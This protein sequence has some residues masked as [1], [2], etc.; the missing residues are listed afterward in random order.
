MKRTLFSLL[1]P[2]CIPVMA[3][4]DNYSKPDESVLKKKLTQL[5]Y[6][7]TQNGAT[8]PPF[9][10]EYWDNHAQ[11][12][13]V[14]VVTGEPLFSS[15]DKFDSGTGWP[16]F[17]KPLKTESIQEKSDLAIGAPRTEI[18][19]AS[20]S[21]HLGHVFDDGPQPTGTRYCVNSASLRFIPKDRLV[22]EGYGQYLSL[23]SEP[24]KQPPTQSSVP[25][26]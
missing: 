12:I 24:G 14:D 18:R 20:G 3:H 4:A 15:T 26:P 10:N 21:T 2:I 8:E 25:T 23:F 6:D 5:Q 9:H 13:Y 16:S 7:V 17:S 11:G 19:S 1:V 22:E